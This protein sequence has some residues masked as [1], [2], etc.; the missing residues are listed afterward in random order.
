MSQVGVNIRK[1][2]FELGMT[3]QELATAM[4]YRTRSTIAKI[5][6]GENDVTQKKL[7][8]FAAV[9]DTSEEALMG[10]MPAAPEREMPAE[11]P[12]PLVEGRSRTAAILLAGGKSVRNRQNIPNQFINILGKPVI[13]YCMEAYQQHPAVDDIYV[14]CL[15]GWEKIVGAYAEQYHITKLRELIPAAAS[16]I[17][18]VENGIAHIREKYGKEDVVILQESTRPMVTTDMISRLLQACYE[19]GSATICRAM[20]D[21]VQFMRGDGGAEYLDR[22]RVVD[23][24]SPEAHRF[25]VLDRV[26][27][28]AKEQGHPLEESC[29]TMLLHNLGFP[30]NFIEGSVSNL[31]IIRQEDIAVATALLKQ[32][33]L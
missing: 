14:V 21:Y 32:N 28:A 4:G 2:R 18:S 10:L 26:F 20:G 24:Q 29:C 17:L 5:E 30:I 27:A 16:G 15:K 19:S 23:L 33:D 1:R 7:R 22:E 9:L 6:S 11:T 12:A 13:V 3:Q 25:S 8:R 31:K